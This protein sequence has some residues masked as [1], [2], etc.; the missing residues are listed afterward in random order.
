M[1]MTVMYNMGA[2]LSL[3]Y[4]N[5][6][7]LQASKSLARLSVGEKIVGA[8]DGDSASY[9]ISEKMRMQIYSLS[10]DDQ[11][12]QNGSAIVKTAE[13]GI[14]QIVQNLRGMKELAINAANDS[15][16]DQDRISIQK[17]FNQHIETINDIAINTQY[18]GKI[19]L[20]GRYA[21]PE[22]KTRLIEGPL[23]PGNGGGNTTVT[24]IVAA[25]KASYNALENT[26]PEMT[27]YKS[28]ASS[29]K[30][31]FNTDKSFTRVDKSISNFSVEINFSLMKVKGDYPRALNGQG[32]TIFCSGCPQYINIL[33]DASRTAAESKYD[34]TAGL[35]EDGSH[36][37]MAREFIIGVKDVRSAEDLPEAIFQGISAVSDEIE[38]SFKAYYRGTVKPSSTGY[39]Y[40]STISAS[41]GILINASHSL[42]IRRDPDNPSKI[43]FTKNDSFYMMF[44]EGTVANPLIDPDIPAK[45][46]EVYESRA[47]NP[48]WVQHGTQSGQRMHVYI[49]DMQTKS[50]GAGQLFNA[51]DRLIRDSDIARYNALSNNSVK[52]S[53][54]I[55]TLKAAENKTLDD[56]SVTTRVNANV[57]IRVLEGAL[58]YVLNEAANLGAYLQK[59]EVT[60]TNIT[61]MNENS[62][63][64][65]STIRDVDMAKE[66]T[67]YTKYNVLAQASQSM[68]AQANQDSGNVIGLLK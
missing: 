35:A 1:A 62:Q 59:L 5:E 51:A 44:K 11:N 25:F 43:L 52:Q 64:A 20:D 37:D 29:P 27:N 33:F 32:F 22:Y 65:E 6:N 55:E 26:K 41:D 24:D 21:R 63:R 49:N 61:T 14:N 18:N 48:L 58:E 56:I 66:M 31:I 17:E 46:E 15:N 60:G 10:Q 34:K 7:D 42:R 39:S 4:L 3:G 2:E 12:V 8:H 67:R 38:R 53:E 40:R 57:A 23:Q 68:L 28:S 36:N 50:L 13:G 54:L 9:A 16:T 45:T 19:L 47:G 30:W